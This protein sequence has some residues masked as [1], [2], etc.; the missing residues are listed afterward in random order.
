MFD[1]QK[2]CI[3]K[4]NVVGSSNMEEETIS[5]IRGRDFL[6]RPCPHCQFEG[7][8]EYLDNRLM[9]PSC[10]EVVPRYMTKRQLL[11]ETRIEDFVN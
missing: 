3:A 10:W 8:R 5:S 9:C 11:E 4:S 2:S 6:G 1:T 7:L